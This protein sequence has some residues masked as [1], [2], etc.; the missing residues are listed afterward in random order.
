MQ[1]RHHPDHCKD[2]H[3]RNSGIIKEIGQH[4]EH[5]CN[6]QHLAQQHKS[7]IGTVVDDLL[8][9]LVTVIQPLLLKFQRRGICCR[10]LRMGILD[11]LH[12]PHLPDSFI[13]EAHQKNCH[14][15]HKVNCIL[16]CPG[17]IASGIS[18]RNSKNTQCLL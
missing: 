14:S 7:L 4:G 13:K 1:G 18:H 15:H 11:H 12:I 2:N 6:R 8:F 9:C 10:K 16:I 3:C 17:Q 5:Q